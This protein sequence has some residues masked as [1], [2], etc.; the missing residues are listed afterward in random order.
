MMQP[1]SHNEYGVYV[2]R[3][4]DN[5]AN[6]RQACVFWYHVSKLAILRAKPLDKVNLL[7]PELDFDLYFL[8]LDIKQGNL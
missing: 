6:P 5:D 4:D 3:L 1:E 8:D 2:V 7:N